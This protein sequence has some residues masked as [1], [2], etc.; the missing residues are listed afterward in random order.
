MK[1]IDRLAAY[2]LE[3]DISP[4][5]F[6]K[7]IGLANGYLGKQLK[8]SGSV[9]SDILEKIANTYTDLNIDWLITGRGA[10]LSKMENRSDSKGR[11]WTMQENQT[12]YR[13]RDRLI[14]ILR[15]QLD[16]LSTPR[17]PAKRSRKKS[18]QKKKK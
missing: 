1:L 18:L 8:V 5:A 14:G 11:S 17:L 7:K 2:L 9:G 10:M 3:K 13:V 12:A 15:E 4:Y 6:E 16:L